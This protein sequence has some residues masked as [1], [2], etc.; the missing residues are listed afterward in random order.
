MKTLML[1]ILGIA[2]SIPTLS[3]AEWVNGYYKNNGT[4][5]EGYNRSNRNNTVRDNYS[6]DG[7]TNPYTGSTGTNK[8]YNNPSSEYYNGSIGGQPSGFKNTWR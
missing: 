5:V 4:Y 8:Y 1:C 6:Y 3:I 7:N 2:I